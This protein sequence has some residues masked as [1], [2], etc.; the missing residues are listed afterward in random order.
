MT[1][2]F[3]RALLSLF[4]PLIL[5]AVTACPGIILENIL[6][7]L[8]PFGAIANSTLSFKS[9]A[10]VDQSSIA[11]YFWNFGDGTSGSGNPVAHVF[12]SPGT[13]TVKVNVALTDGNVL[14]FSKTITIGAGRIYASSFDLTVGGKGISIQSCLIAICDSTLA[15]FTPAGNARGIVLDGAGKLYWSEVGLDRIMVCEIANCVPSVFLV[16]ASS[17]FGLALDG[18]TLYWAV[19]V[20]DEIRFCDIGNCSGTEAVFF[21]GSHLSGPNYLALDGAGNLYWTNVNGPETV[22]VCELTNCAGTVTML[23][24]ST[25]FPQGVDID[26]DKLYWADSFVGILTCTISNCASTTKTLASA[27]NPQGVALD[28]LG[29]IYWA[30]FFANRIRYC[31]IASCTPITVT[32][33]IVE[34][35]A[36]ALE[37]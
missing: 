13:Y 8:G 7:T 1:G 37:F 9:F 6:V 20:G 24:P 36:I 29:G 28:G 14:I 27:Q 18:N 12:S 15:T 16:S 5:L 25:N 22:E 30:E 33:D 3:K 21:S 19:G 10:P 31:G 2:K 35:A 4:A 17:K 34:P 11:A 32:G 23:V 26:G